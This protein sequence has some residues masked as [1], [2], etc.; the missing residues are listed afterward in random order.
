MGTHMSKSKTNTAEQVRSG[1]Q[2]IAPLF[3]SP[4]PTSFRHSGNRVWTQHKAHHAETTCGSMSS[5]TCKKKQSVTNPCILKPA[6]D[7]GK[8]PAGATCTCLQ[9]QPAT[10]NLH[11]LAPLMIP[12][13]QAA[14]KT[15]PATCSSISP[16]RSIIGT[17]IYMG[18]TV[19]SMLNT[20]VPLL[21]GR[22]WHFLTGL[23]RSHSKNKRH[24]RAGCNNKWFVPSKGSGGN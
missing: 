7:P 21:E 22:I 24:Q 20:P 9:S 1:P 18:K 4:F 3:H 11:R 15:S 23:S 16:A 13:L 5:N 19:V 12:T 6:T 14:N 8:F 2:L 17:A 10:C